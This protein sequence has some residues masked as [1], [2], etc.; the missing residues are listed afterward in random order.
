MMTGLANLCPGDGAGLLAIVRCDFD[1]NADI[2]S[3]VIVELP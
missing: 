1:L 3:Q 2:L